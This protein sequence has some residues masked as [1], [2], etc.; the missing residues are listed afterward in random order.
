MLIK[1]FNRQETKTLLNLSFTNSAL[2][3]S[4]DEQSVQDTKL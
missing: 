2:D 4:D 1:S 3:I